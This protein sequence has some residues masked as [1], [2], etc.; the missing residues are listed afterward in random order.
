MNTRNPHGNIRRKLIAGLL[1]LTALAPIPGMAQSSAPL[2]LIV[3]Y[4]AGGP[5]DGGA[6]LIA[7][8]L[9]K[10]LGQTVIVENKPGAGGTTAGDF[11]VHAP[12][13]AQVLYFAA[14]PPMTTGRGCS[15]TRIKC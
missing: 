12:P 5:V 4:A 3:G 8:Y 9:A 1:G 7:P 15:R 11:V 13:S 6:R 14:S 10:E 2:K